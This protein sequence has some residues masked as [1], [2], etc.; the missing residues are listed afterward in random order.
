[1]KLKYILTT[2]D[3]LDGGARFVQKLSCEPFHVMYYQGTVLI[4]REVPHQDKVLHA[5]EQWWAAEDS[6]E[7]WDRSF[8][9]ISKAAGKTAALQCNQAWREATTDRRKKETAA[10]A[11]RWIDTVFETVDLD[12]W[13]DLC[14]QGYDEGL[15][16]LL[17]ANFSSGR[18]L[19]TSSSVR[20]GSVWE[21]RQLSCTA[22]SWDRLPRA[23]SPVD[24]GKRKD[25]Y[26]ALL[27]TLSPVWSCPG[28]GRDLYRLPGRK[29]NRPRCDQHRERQG[30]SD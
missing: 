5:L 3:Q 14:D 2:C 7:T 24:L 19:R 29:E 1:M 4:N 13:D 6:P 16:G 8:E 28:S 26:N 25:V 12:A 22:T 23:K 15:L 9:I 10:A 30:E 17:R 21:E 27:Q 11:A 18:R 20:A